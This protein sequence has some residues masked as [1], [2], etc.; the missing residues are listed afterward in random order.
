MGTRADQMRS[1]LA[2]VRKATIEARGAYTEAEQG[3]TV[4]ED[5]ERRETERRQRR[6]QE[7]SR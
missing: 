5:R 2:A 4:T 1:R 7:V 6:A 3:L